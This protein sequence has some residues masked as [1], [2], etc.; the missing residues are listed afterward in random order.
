M[1]VVGGLVGRWDVGPD[2]AGGIE[3]AA[4]HHRDL[5]RPHAREPLQL[6]HGPDLPRREATDGIDVPIGNRPDRF[7]LAYFRPAGAELGDGDQPVVDA[8]PLFDRS[9]LGHDPT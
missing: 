5:T 9:S 3:V 2:L 8:F 4:A 1:T 6:D 7:R